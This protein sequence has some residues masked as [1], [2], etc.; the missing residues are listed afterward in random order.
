MEIILHKHFIKKFR[1]LP[2]KIQQKFFYRAQLLLED[3]HLPILRNHPVE[4][5]FPDCWSINITGDYRAI[6][7]I[8]EN[9]I[10]FVIIGTH[11]ELY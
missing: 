3:S 10:I 11:S 2:D 6:Y 9:L 7:K 5:A 1:K 4:S 8:Q